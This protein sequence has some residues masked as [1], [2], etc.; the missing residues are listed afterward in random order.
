MQEVIKINFGNNQLSD[1]FDSITNIKRDVGSGW[2]NNSVAQKEGVSII[3]TSRGAKQISFDY[4]LKGTMFD[5]LNSNK[6][7]LA[8]YI[9]VNEPTALIFDDEPNKVWYA[10]PDG[11]QSFTIDNRTGSLTFIVPS[12][13]SE[14]SDAKVLNNDNSGMENGSIVNLS[15]SIKVLANNRGTLPAFP[16]VT[17]TPT[18]ESGFFALLSKNGVLEIGNPDEADDVRKTKQ[19]VIADFSTKSDFDSNFVNDTSWS[20]SWATDFQPIPINSTLKWKNDGVR[21]DNIATSQNWNGGIQRYS[22]PKDSTGVYPTNWHA[23]FN[24][25]FIGGTIDQ[26]GRM[27]VYFCD[28]NKKPQGMFEIYKGSMGR[29]AELI[30][31][32]M[33]SDGT[34][35]RFGGSKFFD[36]KTGKTP[37]GADLFSTNSGGQ[38]IIKQGNK[39]SFYWKGVA[40]T[41]LMNDA[42]SATKLAYIYVVEASRKGYA[43]I[44]DCSLRSFKLTNLNSGYMVDI[45]NKYQPNDNIVIDMENKKITVNG[46]GA[47]S[48]FITGSNFFPIDVG[49]GQ[50]I[51]I[52]YSNFTTSPPKINVEWRERIL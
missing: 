37:D 51:D 7:T 39:Y 27:Q 11:E 45:I 29:T 1:L 21:M 52:S 47:N 50:E 31:Y 2:S 18:A 22:V 4:I 9:N 34:M 19:S 28:E 8:S 17:I 6:Q 13:Y 25:L 12:G 30:F 41:F 46:K 42:N 10:L 3:S 20:S 49:I 23:Q 36:A 14:S 38:G 5:E 48:D 33:G 43:M 26:C 40:Y 44:G 32:L 16:T 24:T 35:Q 15:N